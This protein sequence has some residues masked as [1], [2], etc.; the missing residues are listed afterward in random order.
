[1]ADQKDCKVVKTRDLGGGDNGWLMEIAS[2]RDG[3]SRFLNN[4]QVYLTVLNPGK[5][6]GFHL[7]HKKE[8]QLTCVRGKVVVAIWDGNRIEEISL[9]ADKPITVR[10]P[11]EQ[12]ICFYNPTMDTAYILNLCSPSYDPNDPEQ[13]DLDIP[14]QPDKFKKD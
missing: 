9:D 1:M 12:A 10:V 3:W 6:K 8:N 2:S 14:W 13:E 11:K 5:K 4:A 7:H